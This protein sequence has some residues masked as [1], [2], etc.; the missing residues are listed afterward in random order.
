MKN[1]E[2]EYFVFLAINKKRT[3]SAIW[4]GNLNIS[5]YREKKNLND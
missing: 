1:I 5:E 4:Y 2:I 3:R